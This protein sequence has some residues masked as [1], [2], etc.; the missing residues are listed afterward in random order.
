MTKDPLI[1]IEHIWECIE[2]IEKYTKEKTR[3][4]F[5]ESTQLQDAVIH[6]LEI[7]GEAVKNIPEDFKEKYPEIPWKDIARTR[8]KLI[9]GYFG[10]D[11]DLVWEI[12]QKDIKD[13][14]ENIIPIR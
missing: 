8:D 11:L 2:L 10:I 14:K 5:I 3:A 7:I 13:L 4:E 1:F 6:R 9:H 12:A